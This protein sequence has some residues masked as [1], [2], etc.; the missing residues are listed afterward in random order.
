M[1][2]IL[3]FEFEI[4]F[5]LSIAA[6]RKR[7]ATSVVR[8]PTPPDP[9][10]VLEMKGGSKEA[11]PALPSKTSNASRTG[12]EQGTRASLSNSA[13]ILTYVIHAPPQHVASESSTVQS[14]EE[15]CLNNARTSSMN[16]IARNVQIPIKNSNA[17]SVVIPDLMDR[18]TAPDK[19]AFP[20]K[21]ATCGSYPQNPEFASS[22]SGM[23]MVGLPPFSYD[24]TIVPLLPTAYCLQV[25][26]L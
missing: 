11:N 2:F 20:V 18:P 6:V 5:G 1:V 9:E 26:M 19:A 4:G 16:Y 21:T 7:V 25:S 8:R 17:N 14:G 23:S 10:A 3:E 22:L 13:T 24:T 15:S 12:H